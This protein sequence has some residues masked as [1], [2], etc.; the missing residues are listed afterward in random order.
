METTLDRGSKATEGA[1][2]A[3]AA[4][5]SNRSS[6]NSSTG[7]AGRSMTIDAAVSTMLVGLLGV[8]ALA[9]AL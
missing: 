7:A 2:A 1:A 5:S 6:S 9:M 3:G 4:A 8:A